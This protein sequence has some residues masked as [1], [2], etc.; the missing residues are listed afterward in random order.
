MGLITGPMR[1][2]ARRDLA[3]LTVLRWDDANTFGVESLG[4]GQVRGTGTLALTA[5]ELLFA[6]WVPNRLLR[7]S[8][9][10]ITEVTTTR[11]WLGKTNF[12]Q[13]LLVRWTTDAGADAIALWV[14]DLESWIAALSAP[15]EGAHASP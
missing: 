2:R 8:R 9:A 13:L 4:K 14:K 15:G 1:R 6:Q 3:G 12:R 5:D 11:S 7:I 10:A